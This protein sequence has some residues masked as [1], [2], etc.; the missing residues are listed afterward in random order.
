MI[1]AMGS[2][3]FGFTA[4]DLAGIRIGRTEMLFYNA[5]REAGSNKTEGFLE[6]LFALRF[7]ARMCTLSELLDQIYLH[8][9][10][11][12]IYSAMDDGQTR[13]ENLQYF[14]QL[15]VSY[16][17]STGGDLERFLEYLTIMEADGLS[18][19]DEKNTSGAVTIM[20]IHKSKGLEFPVVYL[21]GLSK[22]FNM[23]DARGQVLC[24]KDL[25]LGLSCVDQ[26]NRVRYPSIVKRAIA[27][28]MMKDMVSEEL[29]VL[30]VAM[31]RARDRLIMTYATHSLDKELWDMSHRMD[32]T[33]PLLLTEEVSSMGE[34]VL[35]AALQRSEA[36]PFFSLGQKPDAAGCK[37]I[38]WKISVAE[39]ECEAE[40]QEQKNDE[41]ETTLDLRVLDAMSRGLY[42]S[43]P[44]RGAT[45]TPSKQTA[46]QLKGR[47]KDQEA[48]EG[49][50]RSAGYMHSFRKPR[51][52]D[53]QRTGAYYGTAL[54]AAMQYIRYSNCKDAQ[55][56]RDEI[57]RLVAEHYLSNEQAEVICTEDIVTLFQSELGNKLIQSDNIVREFK[58]S[59]LDD[60]EQYADGVEGEKILLQGVV[61]CALIESDG[62]TIIDYKTDSVTWDTVKSVAEG[63]RNQVQAYARA[64]ERI[65]NL[66]I[67][68]T[69]LYFFKLGYFLEIL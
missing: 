47:Y 69:L 22:T 12:S 49:A 41:T 37:E 38:P 14:Y 45:Q 25:G 3:V 28:R 48:S 39:A 23:E 15:A 57:S 11:D 54:H 7:Q 24:H 16:E 30:Y 67:K 20:S 44:Y 9:D 40:I 61:D 58:F 32:M 35:Y 46:T 55:G 43:Y 53:Q 63:Y 60:A 29:R 1:A 56:V 26:K 65:Y 6:T 8:T 36:R 10:L 62:I 5:V 59:V 17:N 27:T 51:F 19:S 50:Q 13:L 66:P 21:C 42:Y 68:K 64:M 2:R 33:D 34:W 52:A 18:G 31:T 4:D